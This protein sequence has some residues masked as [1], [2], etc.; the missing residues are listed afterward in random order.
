MNYGVTEQ[1]KLPATSHCWTSNYV[2]EKSLFK[3]NSVVTAGLILNWYASVNEQKYI[4]K[5]S[6][7]SVV[8]SNLNVYKQ[9]T[10]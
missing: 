8:R 9:K 1:P 4:Y 5:D 7:W 2:E 6:I 3:T 10:G